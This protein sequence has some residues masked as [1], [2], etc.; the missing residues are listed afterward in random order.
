MA[1]LEVQPKK[2]RGWFKWLVAIIVLGLILFYFMSN[3]II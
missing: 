1:Q 2:Y 3:K